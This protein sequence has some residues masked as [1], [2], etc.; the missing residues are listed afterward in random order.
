MMISESPWSRAASIS[1]LDMIRKTP[2]L[3]LL[4]ASAFIHTTS[5]RAQ[6]RESGEMP[7]GAQAVLNICE[8]PYFADPTGKEDCTEAI[9][10][11]L[12]DVTRHT[13]LAWRQTI[14]E[15]EA[16]PSQGIHYLNLSAENRRENGV[17]VA[18]THVRLPYLPVIY[19][20]GGTYLVSSTLC[21]RHKDLINTYGSEMNQQI[22]IRGAGADQ[23][24]IRLRDNAPGFEK[25][26]RKPVLSFMQT[27]NTNVATSNYCEDI[28]INCGRGN[29]GAVGLDFFA[30]NT[31]A[32]RNVRI[33]SE[34][35]TGFAGLQ[36]GHSNYSGILI[37]HVEVEGFDHGL[38]I[39]SGTGTMYAHVE[40]V[41]VRGQRISG[42]TVGAISVSLRKVRTTHVPVGL[43]CTSPL[44]HV[45][46]VDSELDGTGPEGIEHRA[47]GLYVS[48]VKLTGFD[49]ARHIDEWVLP[50][51]YGETGEKAMARLSIEETPIYKGSGKTTSGVRL[52]GAL[53]NGINDDSPAIQAAL[54]SGA[55]EI[56][57]EPGR[58]LLNSPVVIPASVEHIDFNFCNLV[59]GV[60]LKQTNLEGFVIGGD[61]DASAPPLFIERLIAWEQW[62]GEHCTFTHASRR[63]VCFKDM[64]TQTLQ[65]YRN[66]VSGGKVFFDNVAATTGAKPGT[67][68]HGRCVVM[69]RG[70][71]VWARQLNPERGE[72]AILN[73]GGELV[74]MGYKSEGRGMVVQTINGGCS[75]VLGGVACFGKPES[76]AFVAED[77][78]IRI[79]TTTY[80]WGVTSHYGT[81]ISDAGRKRTAIIKSED[82]PVRAFDKSMGQR[83]GYLI[84]LYK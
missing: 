58:Y 76:K 50:R 60:D 10:R 69:L 71:K 5:C 22:R 42:I 55:A 17:L 33:V 28:T 39:D 27:E 63:T 47:G 65:F 44:G 53:G 51:A 31:G 75:E 20:P 9:L 37:K 15:L 83:Q 45:V 82:L 73:D 7:Q 59:S 78:E 36:L 14:A 18:T 56:I 54:N 68:G 84:P 30:N 21:Y 52:F 13:Q 67:H 40:D 61:G 34:D 48:N 38:H 1:S 77:S 23:T 25:V 49:D 57:F 72:P 4:L 24:V 29:R 74:L 46:L 80:G 16:L 8:A 81:A 79:S 41:N 19:F 62:S 11:A 12:D 43:T 3:F 66:T 2:V 32:V 64:Q 6:V 26:E 35:G 70:Q